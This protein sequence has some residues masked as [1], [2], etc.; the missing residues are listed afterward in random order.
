MSSVMVNR[1][2]DHDDRLGQGWDFMTV[3][4]QPQQWRG[5]RK[6]G[7]SIFAEDILFV[8]RGIAGK[9]CCTMNCSLVKVALQVQCQVKF[10]A[11]SHPR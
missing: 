5:R 11:L 7:Y 3:A 6:T 10:V 1:K 8:R 4:E 9:K 2:R